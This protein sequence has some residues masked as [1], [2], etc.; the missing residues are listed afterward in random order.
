MP[1]WKR[2]EN[3]TGKCVDRVGERMTAVALDRECQSSDIKSFLP[4]DQTSH[5]RARHS[6]PR[7][8]PHCRVLPLNKVFGMIQETLHF[9]FKSLHTGRPSYLT[10]LLQH[11]Q[12]TTSLRS[13]SFAV[14]RESLSLPAFERHL[15]THSFLSQ[16]TPPPSDPISNA[17]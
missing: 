14:T 17:P 9:T 7:P 15:K 12:P 4:F 3:R 8:A 11:H 10:D 1:R 2:D 16:L 13:F 6:N 5:W